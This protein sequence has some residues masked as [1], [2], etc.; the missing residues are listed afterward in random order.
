MILKFRIPWASQ[1]TNGKLSTTKWLPTT[2]HEATVLISQSLTVSSFSL[3][4]HRWPQ[5]DYL[6]YDLS[7]P[8]GSNAEKNLV[9]DLSHSSKSLRIILIL[10]PGHGHRAG[11][12]LSSS[13]LWL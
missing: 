9:R 7:L 1:G 4:H 11:V 5:Y 10:V 12:E 8:H 13:F 3:F 2:S 6:L